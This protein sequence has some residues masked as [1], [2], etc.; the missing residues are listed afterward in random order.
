VPDSPYPKV[1]SR[2]EMQARMANAGD[3]DD[4]Q[5]AARQHL[6]DAQQKH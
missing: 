2:E 4:L 5:A 6:R 1:N 3:T